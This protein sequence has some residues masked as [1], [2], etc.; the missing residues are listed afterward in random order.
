[1]LCRR[2]HEARDSRGID[3]LGWV[4]VEKDPARW[5][6]V[7]ERSRKVG[8]IAGPHKLWELMG[9]EQ[10]RLDQEVGTMVLLDTHGYARGVVEIARGTRDR[11]GVSLADALRP[12]LIAGTRYNIFTHNHPSG[13]A[14]PSE[15]DAELTQ[16]LER[17]CAEVEMLLVDSVVF[18]WRQF[19]SFRE[20]RLWQV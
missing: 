3:S 15:A 11:V 17:A 2:C 8:P 19:Y 13:Y 4:R 7:V 1:V 6:R 20:R 9:E 10:A 18:G 12:G 16:A 14:T 5:G